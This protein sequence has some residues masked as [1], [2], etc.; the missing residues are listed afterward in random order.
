MCQLS[1]RLRKPGE[2]PGMVW[3]AYATAT[4]SDP[5]RA[6]DGSSTLS[7]A[8]PR[9][10]GKADSSS[11]GSSP[12]TGPSNAPEPPERTIHYPLP[13]DVAPP[14][15]PPN[16]WDASASEHGLVPAS[17]PPLDPHSNLPAPH[18]PSNAHNPMPYSNPPFDTHKFVAALERTFPTSVARGLMRASRAL[19]I[20]RLGRVKRD[21]LTMKDL[22]TSAYLFK[23]ALAELRT[24]TTMLARNETA[25]IRT[26]TAALRREVDALDVR[27]KEDIS[28]LK[29]DIQLDVDTRRNE[30][31]NDL[32]RFDIQVEEVLNKSLVTLYDLRSEVEDVRWNNMRNS[33]VA[34]GGFLLLIMLAME[35]LVIKPAPAKKPKPGSQPPAV[36]IRPPGNMENQPTLWT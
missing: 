5:P 30:A 28:N 14:P 34:L 24:E 33:V 22:E 11:S 15:P 18:L 20:D 10:P 7:A 19:L 13:P 3:R 32:K 23:A 31:K 12:G 27:M 36:E 17:P 9:D 35:I 8:H 29:H 21:A 25:A 26:A 6:P 4:I 2:P 1:W 16:Q